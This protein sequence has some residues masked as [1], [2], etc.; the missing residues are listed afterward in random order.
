MEN[1]GGPQPKPWMQRKI[2]LPAHVAEHIPAVFGKSLP[3]VNE[4]IRSN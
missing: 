1:L 4:S 2:W 3:A